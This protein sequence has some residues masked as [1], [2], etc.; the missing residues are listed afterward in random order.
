M[1]DDRLSSDGKSI[2]QLSD[3]APPMPVS[4]GWA[5][6]LQHVANPVTACP[7]WAELLQHVAKLEARVDTLE[8][9]V[10]NLAID[11]QDRQDI[12]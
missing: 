1:N 7:E 8:A 5:A 4:S 11:D 9:T 12:G 2:N 3:N 6:L 10:A